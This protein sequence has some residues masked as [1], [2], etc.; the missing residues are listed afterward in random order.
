MVAL[1]KP[2][3]VVVM[4]GAPVA[5][6]LFVAVMVIAPP[7]A[8]SPPTAAQE[9]A[10]TGF[11][12]NVRDPAP[13]LPLAEPDG[14]VATVVSTPLKVYATKAPEDDESD[15]LPKILKPVPDGGL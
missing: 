13:G 1:L 14:G 10:I 3:V 9:P 8:L 4:T 6:P 2:P 7:A 5:A 12:I 11:T 15:K